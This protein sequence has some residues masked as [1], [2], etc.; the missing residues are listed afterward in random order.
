[1]LFSLLP[2]GYNYDRFL[3]PVCW[4]L[5]VVAGS[6]LSGFHRQL[7]HRGA[8]VLVTLAFAVAVVWGGGRCVALDRAMAGDRRYALEAAT[9]GTTRASFAR[10][11]MRAPQ[12]FD[13][14]EFPPRGELSLAV[15][16]PYEV[17][18]IPLRD[19]GDFRLAQLFQAL[20]SGACGFRR[21]W[22]ELD[23]PSELRQWIDFTGV[24]SNLAEVDPPL[25]LFRRDP[26]IGPCPAPGVPTQ[27]Q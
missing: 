21:D 25:A 2:L 9:R 22:L 11:A 7:V 14:P 20:S 12:G 5:A 6:G 3:L 13:R 23:R 27:A 1:V 15:L 10:F 4:V 24:L 26:P 17:V 16:S 19:L 8:R 18:A